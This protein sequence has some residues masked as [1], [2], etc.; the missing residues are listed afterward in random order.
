MIYNLDV[1]SE[2]T[3]L[4][5][6][7][8]LYERQRKV[9]CKSLGCC[10]IVIKVNQPYSSSLVDSVVITGHLKSVECPIIDTLSM[11]SRNWGFICS[12]WLRAHLVT[13]FVACSSQFVNRYAKWYLL[14]SKPILKYLSAARS[15]STSSSPRQLY[16]TSLW[17]LLQLSWVALLNFSSIL[18]WSRC[19]LS[20]DPPFSTFWWRLVP[21]LWRYFAGFSFFALFAHL[22]F[23]LIR[24]TR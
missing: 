18:R 23:L 13:S 5:A 2:H 15:I 19:F 10:F 1:R 6:T 11:G 20:F 7:T 17:D 14:K 24:F 8:H 22:V 3:L 9:C 12:W 4:D 21:F 16:F